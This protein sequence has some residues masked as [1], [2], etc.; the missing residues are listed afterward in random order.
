[1]STPR[2][3][4]LLPVYNDAQHLP[5][6]V[7]S[8]FA[9][10]FPDWELLIVDDGSTDATP[11]V[12]RELADRDAR[13]RLLHPGRNVGAPAARALALQHARGQLITLQ[14][15]D[16]YY[17]ERYLERCVALYD[18]AAAAGRRPGLVLCNGYIHGP[19]GLTGELWSERFPWLDDPDLDRM[20]HRN[21][22]IARVMADRAAVEEVGGISQ[23]CAVRHPAVGADAGPDDFRYATCDDYDLW[24][25]LLEAGY[26]AVSTREP[27]AVYRFGGAWRSRDTWVVAD[28]A[29]RALRRALERGALN[30]PQ[31]RAIRR[32]L[33]HQHAL[34]ARGRLREAL[35]GHRP[36]QVASLVPRAVGYGTLAFLQAPSRW[37]EWASDLLGRR[38]TT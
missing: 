10:T 8:I 7:E 26:A 2:V 23:D 20:V 34:I 36:R 31:R 9:Q 5:Q 24:L 38:P 15:S 30:R 6:A 33:R 4:I 37:G 22:V 11:E 29:T 3:S 16:D 12:A 1:M 19:E 32:Q 35:A 14:D 17:L 25:R 21:Y 27:L 28:S 18:E 13:V